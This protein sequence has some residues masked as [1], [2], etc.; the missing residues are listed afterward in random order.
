MYMLR[1]EATSIVKTD[2]HGNSRFFSP[3]DG[4]QK[5]YTTSLVRDHIAI[6]RSIHT[7]LQLTCPSIS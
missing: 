5:G 6:V 4:E 2:H 7:H 1:S 3:Q